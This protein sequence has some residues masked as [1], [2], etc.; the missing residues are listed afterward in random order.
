MVARIVINEALGCLRR[1]RPMTDIAP[2]AESPTL[3][4]QVIAF[5]YPRAEPDPETTIAQR[6]IRALLERAIDKLPRFAWSSSLDWS[7]A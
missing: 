2:L 3:D 5:P 7:K 1:R 6:E 4:A